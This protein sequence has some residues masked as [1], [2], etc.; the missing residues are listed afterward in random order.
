MGFGRIRV[1]FGYQNFVQRQV[2]YNHE[3]IEKYSWV[4]NK[5]NISSIW[6]KHEEVSTTTWDADWYNMWNM[7]DVAIVSHKMKQTL[8]HVCCGNHL[9][10][11]QMITQTVNLLVGYQVEN[12]QE[13]L[14]RSLC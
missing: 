14:T 3:D 6:G 4:N 9:S 11:R 8:T 1:K 12:S 10:Q 7:Q 5:E 13:N 2:P